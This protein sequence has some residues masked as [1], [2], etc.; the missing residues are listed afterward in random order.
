MGERDTYFDFD[1]V[2]DRTKSNSAKWD[3]KVLE[4]G[5]GDPDLLPLWVADMDFKAP[6]PIIEKLVQ[7]AEYGIFGYSIL[8]PSCFESVLTNSP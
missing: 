2:I 8:P 4:K 6:Q 1:Q 3:R 7:T 5:F